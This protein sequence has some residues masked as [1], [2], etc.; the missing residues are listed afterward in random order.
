MPE[1]VEGSGWER[2]RLA[3]QRSAPACSTRC[4]APP[5]SGRG[6]GRGGGSQAGL[7]ARLGDVA[8]RRRGGV[9]DAHPAAAGRRRGEGEDEIVIAAIG[10]EVDVAVELRRVLAGEVHGEGA[11]AAAEVGL[12]ERDAVPG[13]VGAAERAARLAGEVVAVAQH[14]VGGAEGDQQ[15]GEAEQVAVGV[16]QSPVEP[17]DLVV[18]AVG[19]VVAALRAAELVAGE[20]HRH[21]LRAEQ[22]R[23]ARFARLARAQRADRRVVGRALGAAVP[24]EVVV[25]RRRGCPRRSP[26]CASRCRRP[27]RRA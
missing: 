20:Q 10:G 15:P 23:A 12:A 22:Q 9:D 26:R 1:R 13:H 19:V 17:G 2:G 21:A 5:P 4:A 7:P 24:A 11:R 3:A 18:L 25:R 27:G 14:R 16:E 6:R 8:W